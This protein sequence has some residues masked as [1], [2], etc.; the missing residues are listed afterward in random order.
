MAI[1]QNLVVTQ[2]RNVTK[3][4]FNGETAPYVLGITGSAFDAIGGA[5]GAPFVSGITNGTATISKL[6]WSVNGATSGFILTWGPTGPTGAT[7]MSIYGSNGE[8]LFEKM[9]L[10]NDAI[11]PNGTLVISP[12]TSVIGTLI[13]EFGL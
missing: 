12:Q 8:F 6:I 2:K 5:D 10:H 1:K 3:I 4:N 7:A 11:Q 13:I 9:A